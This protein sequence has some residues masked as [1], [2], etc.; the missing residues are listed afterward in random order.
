M[1]MAEMDLILGDQEPRK[2]PNCPSMDSRTQ[3]ISI[4]PDDIR[5]GDN[6]HIFQSECQMVECGK[7]YNSKSLWP[8]YDDAWKCITGSNEAGVELMVGPTTHC[9]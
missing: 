8:T 7:V 5:S 3:F 4:N 1:M 6:E 9:N 2:N